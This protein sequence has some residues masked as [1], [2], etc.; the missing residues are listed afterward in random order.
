M[1]MQRE[2]G[3][4]AERLDHHRAYRQRRDEVRVHG[5]DMNEI[6]KRLNELYLIPQ[7]GEVR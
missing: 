1:A 3:D 7:M 5:V 6:G 2:A 4:P